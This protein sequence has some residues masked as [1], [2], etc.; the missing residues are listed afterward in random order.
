MSAIGDK[1]RFFRQNHDM[2]S[3]GFGP[4]GTKRTKRT[5]AVTAIALV[6]IL[7]IVFV[8][9]PA[10]TGYTVYQ[11]IERQGSTPE[12]YSVELAQV[13]EQLTTTSATLATCQQSESQLSAQAAAY[14]AEA[15]SAK[16]EAQ[17]QANLVNTER[18][19][20]RVLMEDVEDK[21]ARIEELEGSADGIVHR[22][23]QQL[24]CVK[25]VFDDDI[26]SYE[27]DLDEDGDD[28]IICST[29]GANEDE[30]RFALSC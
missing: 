19:R 6:A 22:A 2:H 25:K 16:T 12:T 14:Q 10:F 4:S 20:V 17:N 18:E 9:I 24:C 5:V 23:A 1:L 11:E 26:Q 27:L 29:E 30:K 7:A 3:H 13:K 28:E 15:D 8:G 21:E